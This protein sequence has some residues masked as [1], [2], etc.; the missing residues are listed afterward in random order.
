MK[1]TESKKNNQYPSGKSLLKELQFT[2]GVWVNGKCYWLQDSSEKVIYEE[3]LILQVKQNQINSKISLSS[4]YVSNHGSKP[5]EIKM[6]A[7][8][9]Y[10]NPSQDHFTFVSPTEN[11]IF[12][13]AN[14]NV[15]LVNT[16]YKGEGMKEYTIQPYWNVYSDQI[17]SSLENGSLMY[18]PMSKGPAVSINAQKM[19]LK[20]HETNK[21]N[22]WTICGNNKNEL[23]ALDSALLKNKEQ[24]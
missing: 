7:M 19:T 4:L 21:I 24:F 2:P 8:H 20:P 16:L 22:N 13:V 15:Y 17:W 9:H 23:I 5:K 14:Q 3:E 6:L 10:T 18:Q 11:R 1:L 12:H